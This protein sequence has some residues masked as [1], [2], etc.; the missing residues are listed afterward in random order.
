MFA[1]AEQ[2]SPLAAFVN[3]PDPL[4]DGARIQEVVNAG[5]MVITRADDDTRE[6]RL[7]NPARRQAAFASGA[8]IIRTNFIRPDPA[9]GAYHV[10]LAEESEAM[11][12]SDL[13]SEHCVRF[14]VPVTAYRAIAA[15]A[16]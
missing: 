1:A 8:Q 9:I 6:A 7:N 13:A 11:C 4:R 2:S 12:G 3:I 10:S 14:E 5:F 16:P 15:V